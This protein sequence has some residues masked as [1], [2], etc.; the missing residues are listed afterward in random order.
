M[1]DLHNLDFD[2]LELGTSAARAVAMA[3]DGPVDALMTGSQHTD[4]LMAEL[5]SAAGG[6]R[7]GRRISHVFVMDLPAHARLLLITDAAIN[8]RPTL[9][10]KAGTLCNAIN[11]QAAGDK[12]FVS[13]VA[14]QADILLVPGRGSGNMPARQLQYHAGACSAGVAIGAGVPIAQTSR[15][16]SAPSRLAS[17]TVMARSVGA[18][19]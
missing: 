19:R 8:I 9:D 4:E 1:N 17:A 15:A 11:L 14:G 3:R 2:A 16:G 13:P 7:S 10:E 6:L 5:A 18:A 12:K